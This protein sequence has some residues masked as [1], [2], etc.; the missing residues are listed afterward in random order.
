MRIRRNVGSA[1][2]VGRVSTRGKRVTIRDVAEATGLST[3]A[4]SY[5]LRGLQVSEE[6]RDRVR[7]TATD[8][9]YEA[10]PI[11]RALAGG[12]TGLVGVLFG[13]LDDLWQQQLAAAIGRE[14]L[15]RDRYGLVLDAGNDPAREQSIATRLVDQRVDGLIVSPVD[16]SA[17]G[18]AALAAA[19]PIVTIGDS[20]IGAATAGEVL[21]DN[22][23]GVTLALEHLK[24]LGHRRVAVLTPTRPSTPDRPSDV[25]VSAEATRLGLEVEIV[26]SGHGLDEATAT[27]KRV[28]KAGTSSA[29][30]CFSDSIAYGA[31]AA[32]GE[33]GLSIPADVSVC[34]YDNHPVSRL[35]SPPLTCVDWDLDAIVKRAVKMI[36]AAIDGSPRKQR[37]V[38]P[39]QLTVRGSTAP[40]RPAPR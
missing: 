3:A 34:G 7:Q 37:L 15:A 12:N 18:W 36:V 22:R 11:A 23:A 26:T 20:L 30:F 29:L 21:F 8:L 17:A 31:Y 5:A 14:L 27:A 1:D 32:A 25:H 28:L 39:P 9:G 38:R 16:P 40:P 10:N 33:L 24:G 19:T 2:R 13:S 35:L 6:T 4:V